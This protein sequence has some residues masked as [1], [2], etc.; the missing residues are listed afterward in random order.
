MS[1]EYIPFRPPSIEE[2]LQLAERITTEAT[3]LEGSVIALRSFGAS[4]GA[5]RDGTERIVEA[6]ERDVERMHRV[7]EIL[8]WVGRRADRLHELNRP[9]MQ[10]VPSSVR[11]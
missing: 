1:G 4:F 8:T 3:R 10:A 5:K 7:A 2:A 11:R 9:R 6:L